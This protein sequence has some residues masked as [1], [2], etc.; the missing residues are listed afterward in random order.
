MSWVL[1]LTSSYYNQPPAVIGGYPT[2]D[3]AEQAGE[4]AIVYD[5]ENR[6]VPNYTK[7]TVIPGAACSGPLGSVH[8][9]TDHEAEW[10][11]KKDKFVLKVTRARYAHEVEK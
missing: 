2:R 6:I 3:E 11:K 4:M 8:V 10:D 5:E 9:K 1:I 7:Y